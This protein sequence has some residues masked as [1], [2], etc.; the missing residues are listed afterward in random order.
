MGEQ[1][2]LTRQVQQLVSPEVPATLTQVSFLTPATPPRRSNQVITLLYIHSICCRCLLD[3][4]AA[5]FGRGV[6][7]HTTLTA[8]K[9]K[10]EEVVRKMLKMLWQWFGVVPTVYNVVVNS[11]FLDSLLNKL[12]LKNFF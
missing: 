6:H 1:A 8:G 7:M 3:R 5:S 4:V 9:F 2:I 12:H 11:D 10:T